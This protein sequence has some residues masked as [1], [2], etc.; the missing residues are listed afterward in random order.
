[1]R[2]ATASTEIILRCTPA[3]KGHYVKHARQRQQTLAAFIFE[4]CDKASAYHPDQPP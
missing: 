1:M 3:R 4:T 2:E